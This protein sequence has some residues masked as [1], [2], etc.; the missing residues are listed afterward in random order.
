MNG[1]HIKF[2][3]GIKMGFFKRIKKIVT[4]KANQIADN[5]EE[6]NIEVI[7]KETIN[8]MEAEYIKIKKAVNQ[9][10]TLKKK[11]ENKHQTAKEE[12]AHW[13]DRAKTALENNREDLATEALEKKQEQERLVNKYQ[14]QLKQRTAAVKEHKKKMKELKEK[15]EEA[16]NK[17][18]E[19]IA[20]AKT[21]QATKK[22]NNSLSGVNE[23]DAFNE[24]DKLEDK[25][26][27][28][29]A[30]AGA[31]EEIYESENELDL[32][33]KFADLEK[34]TAKDSVEAELNQLKK[35]LYK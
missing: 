18:D 6:N 33:K 15:L 32:D 35:E 19:L 14:E 2:R 16:K 30:E 17:Q 4:G 29:Q 25:V 28:L 22:I 8:E 3:G 31:S 23:S 5:L 12:V 1:K 10:I 26:E 13:Q 27:D 34:E 20:E 9:S 11:V 24:L 7:V 21:A